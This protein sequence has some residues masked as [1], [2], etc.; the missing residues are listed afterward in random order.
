MTRTAP[1]TGEKAAPGKRN[2][3]EESTGKKEC[4]VREHR[5]KGM[6]GKRVQGK[7]VQGKRSTGGKERAVED[8]DAGFIP[9]FYFLQHVLY[10]M[11]WKLYLF[12]FYCFS[13]VFEK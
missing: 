9:F 4:R 5:G 6:Q 8:F 1:S 10:K 3:G 2:A 7:R 12:F 11:H 13:I